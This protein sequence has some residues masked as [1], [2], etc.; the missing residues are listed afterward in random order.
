MRTWL[1][2]TGYKLITYITWSVPAWWAIRSG[3]PIHSEGPQNTEYS[4]I[5]KWTCLTEEPKH[6]TTT[7]PYLIKPPYLTW[8]NTLWFSESFT[9]PCR[10]LDIYNY[11]YNIISI[12]FH[13]PS[14][15]RAVVFW[16]WNMFEMWCRGMCII[17]RFMISKMRVCGF[18][19][20]L[21]G[22]VDGRWEVCRE[23]GCVSVSVDLL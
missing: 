21:S 7:A 8:M 10:Q 5:M 6:P 9:G 11:I 13:E 12:W 17:Q 18:Y 19:C 22:G 15:E 4:Q 1:C 23:K 2:T 14:A 3:C 20:S 16:T